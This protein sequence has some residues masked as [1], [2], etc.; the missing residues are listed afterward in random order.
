MY[1]FN[2]RPV[3]Y[4]QVYVATPPSIAKSKVTVSKTFRKQTLNFYIKYLSLMH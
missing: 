3:H 2:N 4:V 1:N